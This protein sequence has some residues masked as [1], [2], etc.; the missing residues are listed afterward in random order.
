MLSRRSREEKLGCLFALIGCISGLYYESW[1]FERH[2][3]ALR[4]V[5][6]GTTGSG[7][8]AFA[9]MVL[10]FFVGGLGGMLIG[11]ILS[12]LLPA[13]DPVLRFRSRP[14]ETSS[15]DPSSD[16]KDSVR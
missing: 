16:Q 4:V 10:G 2:V 6:P 8:A 9:G 5:K 15:T 13:G 1:Q 11:M 12:Y 14:K 3:E 7:L